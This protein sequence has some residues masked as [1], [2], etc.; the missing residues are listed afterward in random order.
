MNKKFYFKYFTLAEV[1]LNFKQFYL[2]DRLD[3]IKGYHTG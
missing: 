2:T 3:P 1:S